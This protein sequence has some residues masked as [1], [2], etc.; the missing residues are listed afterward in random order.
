[1]INL[2][3][4]KGRSLSKLEAEPFSKEREIQNLVEGNLETLFERPL[5]L[6]RS[7]F[8]IKDSIKDSRIDTLAY[9]EEN[10]AFVVIEYKKKTSSSLI[11]Q[12]YSYLSALLNHK[13]DFVAEYNEQFGEETGVLKRGAVDWSASRVIFIS[14][15]FNSTQRSA[16]NFKDVPFS[17]WQ[18]KKHTNGFISLE[19]IQPDSKEKLSQ[20]SGASPNKTVSDIEEVSEQVRAYTEEDHLGKGSEK[21]IKIWEG[22]KEKLEALENIEFQPTKLYMGLW[23][24]GTHVARIQIQRKDLQVKII[25]GPRPQ[26]K[27]Q[28]YFA[29][30]DP[31]EIT[32]Q[33]SLYKRDQPGEGFA[34]QFKIEKE[35]EIKYAIFLITQKL[36]FLG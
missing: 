2:Y 27:K 18:I 34:Y 31:K 12:G 28:R 3:S 25:R 6:V 16:A 15:S 1:M 35:S 8:F 10:K 4:L 24:D 32:T 20:I 33:V 9:D 36:E 11:D 7:E 13:A 26:E 23:K 17:L 21:A 22:L 14:P 29:I 5:R 30:D 19:H